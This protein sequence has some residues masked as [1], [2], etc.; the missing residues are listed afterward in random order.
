MIPQSLFLLVVKRKLIAFGTDKLKRVQVV[1]LWM[2]MTTNVKKKKLHYSY[3]DVASFLKH[4]PSF[5]SAAC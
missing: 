2:W 1:H 4:Q 5:R 3:S